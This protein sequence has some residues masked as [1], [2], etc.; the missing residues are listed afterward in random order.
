VTAVENISSGRSISS[1]SSSSSSND[2]S[3]GS[4]SRMRILE[5]AIKG[6]G[7]KREEQDRMNMEKAD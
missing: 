7:K 4:S 1:N 5:E 6:E 2:S 3:S